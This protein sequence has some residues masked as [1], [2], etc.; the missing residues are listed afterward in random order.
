MLQLDS[1]QAEGYAKRCRGR[2]RGAQKFCWLL[3]ACRRR[4][5]DGILA[6]YTQLLAT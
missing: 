3:R 1:D 2:N 4:P 6:R 5:L